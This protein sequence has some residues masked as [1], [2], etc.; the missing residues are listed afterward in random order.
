MPRHDSPLAGAAVVAGR[1]GLSVAEA[2]RAST[3]AFRPLRRSSELVLREVDLF[4][5]G[6]PGTPLAP[7]AAPPLPAEPL[8][9][10]TPE[11][12]EQQQRFARTVA[13]LERYQAAA[14]PWEEPGANIVPRPPLARPNQSDPAAS[15]WSRLWARRKDPA[16]E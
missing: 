14:S 15:P 13:E 11:R 4:G 8:P 5:A 3:L 2:A 12:V 10:V 16:A 7:G 1:H 6:S 9:R